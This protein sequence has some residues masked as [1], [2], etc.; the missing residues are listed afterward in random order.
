MSACVVV[1]LRNTAGPG[2]WCRLRWRLKCTLNSGWKPQ[3]RGPE[4]PTF[5]ITKDMEMGDASQVNGHCRSLPVPEIKVSD[6]IQ[7]ILLVEI[8]THIAQTRFHYFFIKLVVVF[9]FTVLMLQNPTACLSPN[10]KI[11][12]LHG[13]SGRIPLLH[14]KQKGLYNVYKTLKFSQVNSELGWSDFPGFMSVFALWLGNS[15]CK[16]LQCTQSQML[17][18]PLIFSKALFSQP[19]VWNIRQRLWEPFI[20]PMLWF[21]SCITYSKLAPSHVKIWQLMK[22]SF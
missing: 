1:L 15:S 12:P 11:P 18:C 5:G 20:S 10:R 19:L 13:G 8:V 4:L 7:G 17:F 2:S 16:G 14:G 3:K 9:L 6:C 21:Y 22:C